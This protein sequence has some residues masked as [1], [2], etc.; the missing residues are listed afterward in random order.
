MYTRELPMSEEAL[1]PS[2]PY[3]AVKQTLAAQQEQF[4]TRVVA[5]ADIDN[6]TYSHTHADAN[7]SE[8]TDT[9]AAFHVPDI[10]ITGIHLPEVAGYINDGKVAAPPA[11]ISS[12]NGTMVHIARP[13][14]A[15]KHAAG[16]PISAEDYIEDNDY[17]ALI[18]SRG[19]SK[20]DILTLAPE[21]FTRI[22]ERVPGVWTD[23]Q[24]SDRGENLETWGM[25][26]DRNMVVYDI[27]M[28]A[29]TNFVEAEAMIREMATA[30]Y[31]KHTTFLM[32]SGKAKQAGFEGRAYGYFVLP[33]GVGKHT[34]IEYLI[35]KLDA[36]VAT[37][38]GDH[39]ND[40]TALTT[41]YSRPVYRGIVG[42]ASRELHDHIGHHPQE[43]RNWR[44]VVLD[45][46]HRTSLYV[47]GNGKI[48][49]QSATQ[50]VR[51]VI[52]RQHRRAKVRN[53]A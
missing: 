15:E 28:P 42:G 25:V 7:G 51:E 53:S 36:S 24:I 38:V 6:T 17:D 47:E 37:Y 50:F 18:A 9:L 43:G 45:Q 16:Q 52:N 44:P 39:R 12:R 46:G 11:V 34:A 3:T 20:R 26:T 22:Q 19:F 2:D 5:T 35:D 33:Q 49:P 13:S 41:V 10:R 8:Y 27:E 4:G 29:G 23:F 32:E 1:Q 14:A 31:S 21:L 30:Y 48:G 40:A